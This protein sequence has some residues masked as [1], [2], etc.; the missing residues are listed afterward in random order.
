MTAARFTL[1]IADL[2]HHGAQELASA[3]ED[4]V[5]LDPMAIT[6]NETDEAGGPC[7]RNRQ[8]AGAAADIENVFG[9][10][11]LQNGIAEVPHDHLIDELLLYRDLGLPAAEIL[12][13]AIGDHPSGWVI[14]DGDPLADL[15]ALRRVSS[16]V[17]G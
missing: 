1:T 13:L 12:R 2:P 14:L 15:N 9:A 16:V 10:R 8:H 3:L 6:I 5:H 11:T 7:R 4:N 17:A